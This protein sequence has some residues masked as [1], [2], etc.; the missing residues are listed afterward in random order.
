MFTQKS[1]LTQH[2]KTKH[3]GKDVSFNNCIILDSSITHS[4]NFLHQKIQCHKEGCP[5]KFNARR[6]LL[7]HLGMYHPDLAVGL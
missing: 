6:G 1:Q 4:F 7:K 2:A 3:E 5:S